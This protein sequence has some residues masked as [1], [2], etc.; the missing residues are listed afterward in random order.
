MMMFSALNLST[1]WYVYYRDITF[2]SNKTRKNNSNTTKSKSKSKSNENELPST[3][4]L[5]KDGLV[6]EIGGKKE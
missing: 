2:Y 3:D 1:D 5:R 6:T 4:E